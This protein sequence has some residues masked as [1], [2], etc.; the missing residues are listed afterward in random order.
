MGIAS[1]AAPLVRVA[2]AAVGA[3]VRVNVRGFLL[4]FFL[5]KKLYIILDQFFPSLFFF[6][7]G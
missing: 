4:L 3:H 5:E 1:A 7:R 2:A 6:Q